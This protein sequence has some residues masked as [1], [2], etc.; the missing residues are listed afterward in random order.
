MARLADVP[1]E[2][3]L[4]QLASAGYQLICDAELG[5]SEDHVCAVMSEIVD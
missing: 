5:I 1:D 4:Q 3:T 2:E